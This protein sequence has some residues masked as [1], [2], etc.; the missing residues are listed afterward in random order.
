MENCN[1]SFGNRTRELS[2]WGAVPN[3]ATVY[4]LCYFVQILF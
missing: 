4:P 2:V 3:C 1:D